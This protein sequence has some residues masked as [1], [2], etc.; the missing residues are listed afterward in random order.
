MDLRL[1]SLDSSGDFMFETAQ[2]N[3]EVDLVSKEAD[4]VEY[5]FF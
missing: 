5:T 3:L 4:K 2:S 1:S